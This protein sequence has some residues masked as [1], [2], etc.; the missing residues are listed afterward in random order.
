VGD[1]AHTNEFRRVRH[2]TLRAL[3]R[4]KFPSTWDSASLQPRLY[5]FTRFAGLEKIEAFSARKTE[6]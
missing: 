3:N 4:Q 6:D 2:R 5:A 1:S